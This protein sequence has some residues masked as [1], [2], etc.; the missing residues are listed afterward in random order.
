MEIMK[1]YEV[2]HRWHDLFNP[3]SMP[4]LERL[5]QQFRLKKGANVLDVACG[6]AEYLVRL[7]ELY[8]IT[9]VGVDISAQFVKMAR[10]NLDARV[11]DAD[12]KI[13]ELD[14]AKYKE[15]GEDGPFDL[16]MCIGADWI[17]KGVPGTIRAMKDMVKDGGYVAIGSPYWLK[18]PSKEYL[19]LSGV[20]REEY[21]W[22]DHCIE[23]GV[24][25]GLSCIYLVASD[26]DDWDHY[27]SLQWWAVDRYVKDHPDD[28]DGPELLMK[29]REFREHYLR[30]GREYFN[31]AI[32]V[33]RK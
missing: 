31:W 9:G 32:Y 30:G 16:A 27:E 2:S 11:P 1:Y 10:E 15:E 7:A 18:E 5:C 17:F 33:F 21:G 6:R 25:E 4:K 19:E 14:G 26:H 8:E 23:L 13:L 12:I 28:P 22:S 29:A 3:M 20:K 24:K